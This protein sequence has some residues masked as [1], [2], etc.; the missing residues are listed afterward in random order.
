MKVILDDITG[1]ENLY[2]FSLTRSVA[3]IRIGILTIR[4]KWE[5]M[6]NEKEYTFYDI[7]V[8]DYHQP[9]TISCSANLVPSKRD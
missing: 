5:K 3:D 9:G 1:K 2:P 7:D 6:W 4:D 8:K